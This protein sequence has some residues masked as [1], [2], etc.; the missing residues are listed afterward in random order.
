MP[1]KAKKK[2][3]KRRK[4]KDDQHALPTNIRAYHSGQYNVAKPHRFNAKRDASNNPNPPNQNN[5]DKKSQELK[6]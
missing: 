4:E 1:D 3:K 6:R 5:A 2:T